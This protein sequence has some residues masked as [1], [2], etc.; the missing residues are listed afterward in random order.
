MAGSHDG[1]VC[2]C[3]RADGTCA[4]LA[5]RRLSPARVQDLAEE[6]W[7]AASG[8]LLPARPD[9][10]RRSSRAGASAQTAYR[11]RRAQER[12]RWRLG[13]LGLTWVMAGA[14]LAVGLLIGA[15]V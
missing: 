14:A 1:R 7:T 5:V 8:D 11:R 3:D 10:D 12:E 9:G 13:W 2:L 15:T 4:G 6:I